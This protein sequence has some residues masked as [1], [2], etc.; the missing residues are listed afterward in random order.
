MGFIVE[1]I[2]RMIKRLIESEAAGQIEKGRLLQ[3][4][5]RDVLRQMGTKLVSRWVWMI[6]FEKT[7]ANEPVAEFSIAMYIMCAGADWLVKQRI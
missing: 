6:L 3:K 5:D 2:S 7:L 4:E 1:G